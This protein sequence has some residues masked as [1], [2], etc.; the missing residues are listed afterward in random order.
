M[1]NE[2][3]TRVDHYINEMNSVADATKKSSKKMF[4]IF[5]E[6]RSELNIKDFKTFQESIDLDRSSINKMSKITEHPAIIDNLDRLPF[7][8]STLYALVKLTDDQVLELIETKAIDCRSTKSEV[9]KAK[10]Q[11]LGVDA[12]VP[13]NAG[14][15]DAEPPVSDQSDDVS[16]LESDNEP[17]PA[18]FKLA[19]KR[20]PNSK[21]QTRVSEA[22]RVLDEFFD[23]SEVMNY[24][25]PELQEVA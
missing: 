11:L 24:L 18:S 10:K 20:A 9:V 13:A 7:A 12:E 4:A 25:N 14:S 21:D 17:K 2:D 8:W 23:V 3:K 19:L 1:S 16:P 6:A 15:D 22:L 5:L